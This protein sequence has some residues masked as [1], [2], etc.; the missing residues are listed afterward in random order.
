MPFGPYRDFQD[1]VN[2]NQDVDDPEAYC[3][4]LE[5][6]LKDEA[7]G[8]SSDDMKLQIVRVPEPVFADEN[9][10]GIDDVTGEPVEEVVEEIVEE[11]EEQVDGPLDE[12]HSLLVVEGVWTGD[13]RYIDE[14]ALSWRNLP[15][16][17][18]GLDKT[19]E[20]HMEARLIGNITRI[21]R[22]GRE[23]HGYGVFVQS[24]DDEV[25]RLQRLINDGSLRGVSVD[26]D[27][28]E[29]EVVIP[30]G[31]NQPEETVDENGDTSMPVEDMK[32]RVTAARIMGA[33]VVPFPAFEEAYIESLASL[34]AAL[35]LDCQVSGYI[36]KFQS[37]D[38]IDFTAPQGA[39]E[40]AE[41]GLAWRDEYNRGGTAVGV[42]R[43]R[44]IANGKNLSPDT[45]NRMVSYF[46]RHEVDKQ[47]EGWSPDEDGF[48]SAGRIA[49]AL[50][51]GDPGRTWAEKV[52]GQMQS[53]EE[54]GSVVASGHPVEAPVC[55]PASWFDNPELSGP[56]PMTVT[57]EGRIF[58][59]V[60]TWGS[61]HIGFTDQCVT[62]PRSKAAYQHYLTG[63]I[64][65]EDG[66]RVPVGQI[67][68]DTGHAP[69]NAN[70]ARALA[71]YDNTGTAVADVRTGE[72]QY[73]IWMAGAL[74][75]NL[76]SV[77]IRGLMASD[78]S[79]D[80]RRIGGNLELVGVLAVNVPGF[81]KARVQ[82]HE[83]EGLIASLIASIPAEPQD[84]PQS[85]LSR[86]VDRIAASIGRDKKK[87]VEELR[88][89]VRKEDN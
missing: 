66:T 34:T 81:P 70:G 73:G 25:L 22:E 40:E 83:N 78:V 16:P 29:Y 54:S 63:E 60:A 52:Q 59:H 13:G 88:K 19:T 64:V 18:M 32:M 58:G 9:G 37:F 53:R 12:F 38:D 55:P 49:W 33:T 86:V 80:W 11:I 2:K 30:A 48:P 61:C 35:T 69:L 1:C 89:K 71:H 14:E 45:I 23:I 21:E 57:D 75:P 8:V 26:L 17:L 20:A 5:N 50:W 27:A 87:R 51:G 3:A 47:G 24:E 74:R 41:K 28:M 42:A 67:T 62:P 4:W 77:K 36:S 10:D 82:V 46:A 72:D 68:M 6:E 84:K 31:M 7:N 85:D 43:A 56:T 65:C 15:L 44:D 76:D 79:G 39:R